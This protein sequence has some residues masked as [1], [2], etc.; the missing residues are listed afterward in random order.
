MGNRNNSNVQQVQS[1]IRS[2]R[3]R[4]SYKLPMSHTSKYICPIETSSRSMVM[5]WILPTAGTSFSG[6]ALYI[7]WLY[8][9]HPTNDQ[10]KRILDKSERPLLVA[11]F[12]CIYHFT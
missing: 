10:G 8:P 3:F 6:M 9:F 12:L 7:T 2:V 5:F 1:R 4:L 11:R